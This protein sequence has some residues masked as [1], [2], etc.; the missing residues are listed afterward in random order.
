MVMVNRKVRPRKVILIASGNRK[1]D[2]CCVTITNPSRAIL[3]HHHGL[4]HY[5]WFEL[6]V[7]EANELRTRLSAFL[8]LAR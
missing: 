3:H 5:V 1:Y 4:G 7:K 8:K 2:S 6:N